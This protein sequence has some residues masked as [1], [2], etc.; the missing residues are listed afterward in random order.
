MCSADAYVFG[1]GPRGPLL[2]STWHSADWVRIGLEIVRLILAA[3]SGA[4][5]GVMVQ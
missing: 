1:S 2:M 5:A 4:G 3:L